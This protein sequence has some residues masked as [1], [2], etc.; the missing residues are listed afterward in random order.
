MASSPAA[1][2]T[3]T[4]R[5]R[6]LSAAALLGTAALAT[7]GAARVASPSWVGVVELWTPRHP[8]PLPRILLPTAS[9]A[10]PCTGMP[11]ALL[12]SAAPPPACAV[13]TTHAVAPGARTVMVTVTTMVAVAV[14]S[15]MA[16]SVVPGPATPNA[17][18]RCVAP[19]SATAAPPMPTVA[20]AARLPTATV[21]AAPP[22]PAPPLSSP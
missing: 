13:P 7:R 14:V 6:T 10:A 18:T 16:A 11:S 5:A 20:A 22:P 17:P 19:V 3:C 8:L 15:L 4:S 21:A 1:K 9:C 2:T 12:A